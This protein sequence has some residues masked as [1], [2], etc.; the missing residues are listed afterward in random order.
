MQNLLEERVTQAV[1]GVSA[2]IVEVLIETFKAVNEVGSDSAQTV[3]L[4]RGIRALIKL[5]T[6]AK[7]EVSGTAFAATDLEALVSLLQEPTAQALLSGYDPLAK[8]KIRG[9]AAQSKLLAAEGGCVSSH[10]AAELIGLSPQAVDKARKKGQLIAFPRG[11]NR[12]AYPHWQFE[13]GHALKGLKEVL[14]AL[15]AEAT[16]WV[17][18]GFILGKN[19]RLGERRPLDLLRK[20]KIDKVI[21]AA[22][23]FGEHGAA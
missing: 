4:V 10:E 20:G 1:R 6:E 17:K 5:I 22:K 14:Q 15:A 2:P 23:S 3:V 8:A 11:Q 21:A 12:Y 19:S 9:L 7:D 18:A 13:Q 16:P